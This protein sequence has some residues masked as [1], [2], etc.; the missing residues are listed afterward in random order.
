MRK[1][2]RTS[3][4][5]FRT[6]ESEKPKT[7]ATVPVESAPLEEAGT[8]LPIGSSSEVECPD[9]V[10]QLNFGGTIITALRSTLMSSPSNF[11]QWIREDFDGFPR[12]SKGIPFF[13]RDPIVFKH[14]LNFLR[15]Y[16]LPEE[17]DI[18][19]FLA[20]D[21]EYFNLKEIM[22]IIGPQKGSLKFLPG[23]GVSP[24]GKEFT[25]K[26]IV[27]ICGAKAIY[28]DEKERFVTFFLE[29]AAM[30]E[31]GVV[32]A[33][34]VVRNTMLSSQSRSISLRSTGEV[35]IKLSEE[36]LQDATELSR[37][38]SITVRLSF[39]KVPNKEDVAPADSEMPN[40]NSEE[41]SNLE[42]VPASR[43]SKFLEL[44]HVDISSMLANLST[45]PA[46]SSYSATII[47]ETGDRKI[48]VE[49]PAPV[50]PLFFAASLKGLSF[51]SIMKSSE[52][53]SFAGD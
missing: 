11:E 20:E 22:N 30:V 8:A 6:E 9:K 32:A 52:P 17:T 26:A 43:L 48:T 21:A 23:P 38:D 47:F 45:S 14:I 13:E 7:G 19:P 27:G 18:Y 5:A 35:M 37:G 4:H 31:V 25:T 3:D 24:D 33:D 34:N 16:G 10:L 36:V 40:R 49:W 39:S 53:D 2:Q 28:P 46:G 12:D 1:R 51:V 44:T 42:F 29:K 41:L 15:G 50:P